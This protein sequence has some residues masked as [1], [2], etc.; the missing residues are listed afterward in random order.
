[1]GADEK[2]AEHI[3]LEHSRDH[4]LR[5]HGRAVTRSLAGTCHCHGV[6]RLLSIWED[7]PDDPHRESR[8]R[9]CDSE[10]S[11]ATGHRRGSAGPVCL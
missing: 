7:C 11:Q 4:I 6:H 9:G 3:S 1:M 2:V 5:V 8:C 10:S